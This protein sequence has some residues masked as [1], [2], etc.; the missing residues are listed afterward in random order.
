M[1]NTKHARIIVIINLSQIPK[2]ILRNENR[3]ISTFDSL[4]YMKY[5]R[6]NSYLKSFVIFQSYVMTSFSFSMSV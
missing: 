2:G 6:P 5:I 3:L 4:G 1:L